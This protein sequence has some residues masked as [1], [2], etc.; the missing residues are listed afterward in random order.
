MPSV[1]DTLAADAQRTAV[2]AQFRG[3]PWGR[4][5]VDPWGQALAK[6]FG[7]GRAARIL[8]IR[9]CR[10]GGR[11]RKHTLSR[12]RVMNVEWRCASCG[13]VSEILDA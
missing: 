2:T 1:A 3:T 8:D 6:F 11:L 9:R 5:F 10:C 12:H 13:R 7:A 4:R